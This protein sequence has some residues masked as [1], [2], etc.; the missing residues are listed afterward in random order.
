MTGTTGSAAYYS[1][2]P[3]PGTGRTGYITIQT[4]MGSI[5]YFSLSQNPTGVTC[6]Y[7][8]N[9][10]QSS[11]AASG[12]SSSATVT[13]NNAGCAWSTVSNDPSWITI[14][15]G[16]NGS[17]SAQI[18]VAPNYAAAARTGS[19]VIAGQAFTI[20]QAGTITPPGGPTISSIKAKTSKVGSVATI[21]GT[22]FSTVVKK[23]AVYFGTKKARI[24]KA[25][26]TSL[27][28]TIP[29]VGKG[30]VAVKVVV[31][32]KTSNSVQFQ[33]K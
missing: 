15:G 18:Q 25:K 22:G 6:T 4:I 17:G 11:Y 31:N 10:V 28:V 20:S 33:V 30:M 1:V 24:S 29:K 7:A 23:D 16:G 19:V 9:G 5:A 12:G 27:K 21:Y 14:S 3:N 8:V 32:G 2:D 13:A 26:A